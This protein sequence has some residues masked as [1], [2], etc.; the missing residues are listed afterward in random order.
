MGKSRFVIATLASFIVGIFLGDLLK[1][2][3]WWLVGSAL[4]II[5]ALV[6]FWREIYWRLGLFI[7]LGLIIGL[8]YFSFWDNREK[9]IELPYGEELTIEGQIIGHPDFS[10]NLAQYII[11][12]N[13]KDNIKIQLTGNR[14]PEYH[15]GDV[16][17]FKGI[18]KRPSDYLFHRGILGQVSSEEPLEKIIGSGNIA[19]KL[20]YKIRDQFEDSLNRSLAE[21]YAS[22]AAGLVLGSK[23]NIPDSLMSDLNRT[24]TTH[25]IAVSGYNVTIIIVYIAILLGIFSR[26]VSFYGSILTILIFVIMTGAVASV[27]RAGILA[28][29]VAF[30]RYESRRINMTILL[31]LVAAIM[32]FFNP[33]A[34][35]YD[36]GFELSFLAFAG[37]V[38]LS[39]IISKLKV[40]QFIPEKLRNILA[41][42]LGA[43]IMVL[44]ILVFYFG[45]ASITSPIVNI[46]ILWM[47]P[48]AM[49]MIFMV[50]IAGL[51]WINLGQILGYIGWL[52]LKYVVVV[53]ESFSKI[54]WSSW[55]IKTDSWWWISIFYFVIG[56]LIY[57]IRV[58]I[59]ANEE[60]EI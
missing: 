52:L 9:T 45:R 54:P 42:T 37:L 33:Y 12:Y 15:Y 38:Y 58:R 51:I 47:I 5:L 55:Q 14:Y 16:L 30:G 25:I 10:G 19:I 41:E 18:I 31:L 53:V 6:I 49:G 24:G 23:R 13:A 35:K 43:Q 32:L 44:P 21:P 46:L 59:K 39:P 3:L 7:F 36:V 50:G 56:L 28:G 60:K 4:G 48:A 34:I 2:D 17:K 40:T 11:R 22:F 27:V 26:R 57:N 29:L 20:I 8:G 1:V